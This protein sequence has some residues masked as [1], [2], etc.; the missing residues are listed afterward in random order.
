MGSI[1]LSPEEANARVLRGD[2]VVFVDS[3]KPEAWGQ[4]DRMIP[5]AIRI[6]VD[7]VDDHIQELNKEETVIAYCT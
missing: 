6:P 5:G 3:R 4:S 7:A 2:R 1:R